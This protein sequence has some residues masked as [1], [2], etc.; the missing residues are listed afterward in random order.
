MVYTRRV[1]GALERS[2]GGGSAVDIGALCA[3]AS[4][5]DEEAVAALLASHHARLIGF[6]RRKVGVDWS[7]K[8]EPEDLV[9]EAYGEAFAKI[10][11]FSPEGDDAFYRWVSKIVDHRFIDQVRKFRSQKRDAKREIRGGDAARASRADALLGQ[12]EG[13]E[14][15]ASAV[16]RRE[17]AIGAMM[18]C[19][20]R[21]PEDY[22]QVVTRV[23]LDGATF[24]EVAEEMGRTEDALRRLAGRA[25]EKMQERM[26]TLT[27][28]L[29][30][31]G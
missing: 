22:R 24:A 13:A 17:D 25:L 14:R 3:R 2:D 1:D 16:M 26:G 20:A 18:A 30:G 10:G 27:R 23:Y 6:A 7:G 28:Y 5:G 8:I 19:L 29:S 11:E 9:Q 21:L 4:G 31:R 12:V 15:T